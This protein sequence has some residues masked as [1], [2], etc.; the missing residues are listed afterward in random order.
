MQLKDVKSLSGVDSA[1]ELVQVQ[2]L[3][4]ADRYFRIG[5]NMQLEDQVEVLLSLIQNLDIFA[6]NPYKVHEVD[7]TFLMHR[8]NVDP[9]VM[10]KK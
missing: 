4:Y 8:L 3:P 7:P 1:E 6:W 5:K 10:P 2:I 9:S